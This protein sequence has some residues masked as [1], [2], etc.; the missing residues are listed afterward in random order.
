MLA[1]A[2]FSRFDMAFDDKSIQRRVSCIVTLDCRSKSI[3]QK[4]NTDQTFSG[5]KMDHR[6]WYHGS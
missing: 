1:L 2:I 3:I 5:G 4:V 6:A